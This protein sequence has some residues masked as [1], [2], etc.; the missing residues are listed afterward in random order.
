MFRIVNTSKLY[1]LFK[2]LPQ[3]VILFFNGLVFCFFGGLFPTLFAAVQAAEHGGRQTFIDALGDLSEEFM[4]IIEESKKDDKEDKD[5]D[6]KSDV[7]Q[8]SSGEYIARKTTLVLRKMNPEKV[9]KAFSSMY[10]IWLAV[11]AVLSIQFARTV[12]MALSIADFLK[13]PCKY[14]L[15]T[16]V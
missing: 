7:D 10:R 16:S 2:K 8:I 1:A 11:A 13:K 14:I 9:D 3:N 6:G 12:S 15:S 4:T 5:K